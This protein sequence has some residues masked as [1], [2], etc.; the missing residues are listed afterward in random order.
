M[1]IFLNPGAFHFHC[2]TPDGP[3]PRRLHTL[4]GSC[5]SIVLWHPERHIGAMSHIIL[6]RRKSGAHGTAP[7]PRYADE[8]VDLLCQCIERAGTRVQQYQVYVVGG[9]KMYLTDVEKFSVGARNVAA[10]C[11]QLKRAGFH[12]P[13]QHVGT[14]HHRKVELDLATGAVTVN[15]NNQTAVLSDQNTGK[16]P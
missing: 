6:P 3:Q 15:W 4:L 8:A 2:P 7:D 14:R 5:V 1:G 11:A 16:K 10:V 9:G 13:T 12:A